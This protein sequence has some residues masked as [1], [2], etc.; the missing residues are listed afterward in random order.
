MSLLNLFKQRSATDTLAGLRCDMH[1]HL[2]PGI[3]DGARDME[4]SLRLITGLRELGYRKLIT[5]PHINGDYFPNTP[6]TILSGLA[7]VQ[8]AVKDHRIDVEIEAAAEYLLDEHFSI[9]LDGGPPL[10]TFHGNWVLVE[11]S[12]VV[13][14]M[15]SMDTLF[16][17]QM[18]G[19]QPVLAHPERY[20]YFGADRGW[21][22]RLR[23]AGC[24]F[25]LNLL[26]L[27]GHYGKLA[28]QLA[29]Y[30]VKKRYIDLLGTDLHHEKH[31][32]LLGSSSVIQNTVAKLLDS[33]MI[34]NAEL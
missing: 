14:A 21:Y 29:G 28:Y 10:L 17:L 13:P 6:E 5:T 25:Q 30:L 27:K 2:I 24:L 12:F 18:K 23:D 34:R 19:Y 32:Q 31:L 7:A 4:M 1:S 33:G 8:A 9:L 26:S 11:F 22:D 20:L 16:N 15:N 3:D